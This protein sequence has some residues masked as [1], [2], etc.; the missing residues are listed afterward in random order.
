[1]YG[2][3]DEEADQLG[4][5]LKILRWVY[6]LIDAPIQTWRCNHRGEAQIEG[7]VHGPGVP[8]T[9]QVGRITV[10]AHE[11]AGAARVLGGG[12]WTVDLGGLRNAKPGRWDFLGHVPKEFAAITFTVQSGE[13]TLA[14]H[15]KYKNV[16]RSAFRLQG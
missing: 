7:V 13:Y 12:P 11:M 4:D 1:M 9:L 16:V 8:L 2:I 10:S 15:P 3:F 5:L 6:R 14:Y